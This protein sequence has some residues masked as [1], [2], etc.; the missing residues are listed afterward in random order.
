M[1]SADH[2]PNTF[3]IEVVPSPCVIIIFGATGDL[4]KRKIMPSLC[5]LCSNGL[6]HEHTSIVACGRTAHSTKSFGEYIR[7]YIQKCAPHK[8]K[9]SCLLEKIT[10]VRTDPNDPQTFNDLAA[11][12]NEKNKSETAAPLNYL[13]YFAVPPASAETLIA[14]LSNAGLLTEKDPD[15]W[16][17]LALEKPFGSDLQSALDLDHFLHQHIAEDNIYRIDHYL[18]K[19]TVQNI[20]I[21][22]FA[23]RIFE[24]IWDHHAIDHIL[25]STSETVGLEGR[26]AYFDKSGLLRDMFQSH[27]MEILMLIAMEPP[28]SF[29]AET[30]HAAKLK[31]IKSIRPFTNESIASDVIRAQYT[32]G[33]D[34]PGYL[35]EPDIPADSM[36]ET[37]IAMKLFIDNDRW[38]DV[39]IYMQAGKRMRTQD[40]AIKIVFKPSTRSIFSQQLAKSL[41]SNTLTLRIRPDEGMGLNLQA[42]HNGPKLAIGNITFDTTYDQHSNNPDAPDAYARLL[43]DAML[44]DHTLF[45]RSKTIIESWRLFTPIMTAWQNN[46]AKYPLLSYPAG[47]DGPRLDD[48]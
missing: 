41:T 42:K 22:R 4:T 20:L 26:N 9:K 46:P 39:P 27:L 35:Q 31:L 38:K 48:A 13:F 45:V 17:H 3:S 37:F 16:R 15:A 40:S 24:T 34:M 43:L 33:N 25:I 19:E 28:E 30:I 8:T 47:S 1:T 6:L 5:Q 21:T 11:H 14:A 18:A 7:T 10:Y 29:E 44:H 2:H 12:L 23:N 36:T 32:E